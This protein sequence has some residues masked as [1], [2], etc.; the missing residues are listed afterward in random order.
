MVEEEFEDITS[1]L[2]KSFKGWVDDVRLEVD[3]IS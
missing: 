2:R 1:K 3:K